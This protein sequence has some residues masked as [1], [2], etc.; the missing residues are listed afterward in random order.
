MQ[1]NRKQLAAQVADLEKRNTDL[2]MSFPKYTVALMDCVCTLIYSK[3]TV[4]HRGRSKGA[5]L[6]EIQDAV[7]AQALIEFTSAQTNGREG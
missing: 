3:F 7:R 1:M 4:L 5:S 2:V 6:R